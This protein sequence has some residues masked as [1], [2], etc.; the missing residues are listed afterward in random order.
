MDF[1]DNEHDHRVS[2]EIDGSEL[3]IT[4]V[5][6]SRAFIAGGL[7]ACGA[8]TVSHP[9][10]TI[11]IRSVPPEFKSH[12]RLTIHL[13]LSL[14]LQGELQAKGQ[15]PRVYKN[16]LHG[17]KVV[18]QNEG[19]RGLWRGVGAGVSSIFPVFSSRL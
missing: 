8:V 5:L 12:T 4:L 7:A 16:V 14:Q 2:S 15:A 18:A 13:S 17:V 11:K 3:K 9:F 19:P 1:C 10:E 6:S